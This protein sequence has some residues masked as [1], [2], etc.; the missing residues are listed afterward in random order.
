MIEAINCNVDIHKSNIVS[1]HLSSYHVWQLKVSH[2]RYQTCVSESSQQ[3]VTAVFERF[4]ADQPNYVLSL[5]CGKL[6]NM[7]LCFQ[8]ATWFWLIR[9][10]D[11]ID[12]RISI[13]WF[14]GS[15][16]IS[17]CFAKGCLSTIVWLLQVIG[18]H[19]IWWHEVYM[20]EQ[21]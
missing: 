1:N 9:L 3:N 18:S 6:V 13:Q 8:V 20:E 14:G 4:V 19:Y 17:V 12:L 11:N 15:R 16:V 21:R 2:W 10:A 7:S 5:S